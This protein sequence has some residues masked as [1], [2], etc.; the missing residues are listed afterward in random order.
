MAHDF[1]GK[2]VFITGAS[3][4]IGAALAQAFQSAG[5]T[6]I[7]TSRSAD[8]LPSWLQHGVVMDVTDAD[9]VAQGCATVEQEHGAVD[10]VV[11]NAGIGLF[12]AWHE[13]SIAEYQRI[14]DV[15][16]YGAIRV[17]QALLPGMVERG[18]GTLV[19]IASVAGERGYPKHSAYC[20]SKHAMLGWSKGLRKDLKG[21]GVHMVDICPPAID[22]PFFEN[23]GFLDYRE[24]HPGLELM[25]PETVAEHTLDA[26]ARKQRGRIL[27]RRARILWLLDTLSPASLDLLQRFK[28]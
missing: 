3:S 7:G 21:T 20:A 16:L 22:T 2:T 11:N 4:G 18:S 12:M 28:S 17:T 1:Q 27:G 8:R 24:K 5:A 15:N 26:V 14:M 10:I 25:S 6:V 23:A 9:S 19:N 13:T